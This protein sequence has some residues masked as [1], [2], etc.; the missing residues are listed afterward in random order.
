VIRSMFLRRRLHAVANRSLPQPQQMQA[1]LWLTGHNYP[2][3]HACCCLRITAAIAVVHRS[4]TIA[5]H[6]MLARQSGTTKSSCRPDDGCSA[7]SERI[8][9]NAD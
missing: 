3:P 9:R 4:S 6:P 2:D 1:K 5:N 7:R 8:R